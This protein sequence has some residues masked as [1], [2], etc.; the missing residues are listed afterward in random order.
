MVILEISMP[1]GPCLQS[2]CR[3]VTPPFPALH[4]NNLSGAILLMFLKNFLYATFNALFALSFPQEQLMMVLPFSNAYLRE[5]NA[6]VE[7]LILSSGGYML[8]KLIINLFP[9]G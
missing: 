7:K 3:V 5:R 4:T 6:S 8:Y 9:R 1:P 2:L